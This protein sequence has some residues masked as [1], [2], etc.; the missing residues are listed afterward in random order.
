[1]LMGPK[2]I[3][4]MSVDMRQPPNHLRARARQQSFGRPGER[5]N[6]ARL[7]RVPRTQA[8]QANN[9]QTTRTGGKTDWADLTER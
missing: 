3:T 7:Q 6:P 8:T 2:R 5:R 1:M 9:R 4:I